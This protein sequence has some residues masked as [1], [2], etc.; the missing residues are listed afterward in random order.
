MKIQSSLPEVSL[1]KGVLKIYSKVTGQHPCW[2]AISIKL[3]RKF[4][5]IALWHGCSPVLCCIFSEHLFIKTH[6]EGCFWRSLL[7]VCAKECMVSVSY[8]VIIIIIVIISS[9]KCC[10]HTVICQA[11]NLRPEADER[12]CLSLYICYV[13]DWED[14]LEYVSSVCK[15]NFLHFLSVLTRYLISEILCS[16]FNHS[17]CSSCH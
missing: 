5:E 7:I 14:F 1:G 8:E 15:Y 12:L 17:Q 13:L 11:F 10:F 16:L 9:F 6:M 3:L 4:I 2:S